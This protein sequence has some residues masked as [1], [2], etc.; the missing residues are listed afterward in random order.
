MIF[1]GVLFLRQF[2]YFEQDSELNKLGRNQ[3]VSSQ[4]KCIFEQ[5][6]LK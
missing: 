1:F 6:K 2:A 3:V 5:I 4:N